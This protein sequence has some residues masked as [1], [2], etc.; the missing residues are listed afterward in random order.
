MTLSFETEQYCTHTYKKLYCIRYRLE[1]YVAT[2][3]LQRKLSKSS[4]VNDYRL[5]QANYGA[6]FA[7]SSNGNKAFTAL[8][9][10]ALGNLISVQRT[11]V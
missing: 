10:R 9:F 1:A 5:L 2:H 7:S 3:S 4:I 8:V 6:V 11:T